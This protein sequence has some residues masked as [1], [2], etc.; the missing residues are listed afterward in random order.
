MNPKMKWLVGIATLLLIVCAG[1]YVYASVYYWKSES[2]IIRSIASTFRLSAAKVGDRA[3]SY[4]TYLAHVDAQRA[5]LQGPLAAD[6]GATRDVTDAERQQALERAIRIEAVEGLAAESKLEV[7]SLDVDRAFDDLVARAGT[8]T[9]QEEITAF[10]RA[11]FGWDEVSYKRYLL[12]PAY[13]EEIM[14]SKGGDNFDQALQAR[15]DGA[16]RYLKF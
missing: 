3:V 11:Q 9:S 1:G 5:F 12:R 2:P 7:T 8:S 14:R 4:D 15:I 10:L 16:A 6:A 13:I